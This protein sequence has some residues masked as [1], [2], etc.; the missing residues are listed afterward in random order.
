MFRIALLMTAMSSYSFAYEKSDTQEVLQQWLNLEQQIGS[1]QSNWKIRKV[2]LEQQLSLLNKEQEA[3]EKLI[4]FSKNNSTKVSERRI[5]LVEEQT[6][7]EQHQAKSTI[8]IQAIIS[9]LNRTKPTLPAPVQTLWAAELPTLEANKDNSNRL[10]SIT[11]LLKQADDFNNR[12][13]L[14]TG[15][16][17]IPTSGG[18]Q[19]ILV[20][21]IYLGLSHG[22]YISAD[23]QFYGY[24]QSNK[25]GW[26]WWHNNEAQELLTSP[27][28]AD[29]I[30]QVATIIRTPTQAKYVQLPLALLNNDQG[31]L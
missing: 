14:H 4:E 31:S 20:D 18:T 26:R 24:G 1:I 28:S 22:W 3:L 27:I 30:A 29:Q 9:H 5:E 19:Q 10:E 17:N 13:A 2:T 15:L 25:N 7:L 6:K 12:V 21:Q 8:N 23:K 16:L 11:K